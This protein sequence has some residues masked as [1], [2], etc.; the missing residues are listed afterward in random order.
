MA[1]SLDLFNEIR[2]LR[3]KVDDLGALTETLVRAQSKE[4]VAGMVDQFDGDEVLKEFFLAVDGVRSQKEITE[5]LSAANIRGATRSTV[6]RKVDTL[7]NDLHLIELVER[8]SRGNV[9][10]RTNIDRILGISRKL[11][12]S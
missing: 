10:R 12:G 6:S 11:S 7:E 9:Y 5:A 8:N 1:E 4:L 3:S 2:Q